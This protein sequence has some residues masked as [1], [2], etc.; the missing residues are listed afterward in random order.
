MNFWPTAL[1]VLFTWMHSLRVSDPFRVKRTVWLMFSTLLVSLPLP[2]LPVTQTRALPP[3]HQS[4]VNAHDLQ[5]H[6]ARRARP[7]LRRVRTTPLTN[8]LPP[9]S[10]LSRER[11]PFSQPGVGERTQRWVPP[12]THLHDFGTWFTPFFKFW[13]NDKEDQF[14][15]RRT[16][17]TSF[18]LASLRNTWANIQGWSHQVVGRRHRLPDQSWAPAVNLGSHSDLVGLDVSVRGSKK[19]WKA[20][21]THTFCRKSSSLPAAKIW[22]W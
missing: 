8:P 21:W 13:S 9:P 14:S 18:D 3:A 20:C 2:A 12:T 19:T 10:R 7:W 4:C 15:E 6:R 5:H 22:L 1:P 11:T 17:E 16:A